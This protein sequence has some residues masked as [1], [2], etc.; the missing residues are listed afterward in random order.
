MGVRLAGVVRMK[1]ILQ[2]S[3]RNQQKATASA[4]VPKGHFAVY[5]GEMEKRFV[6]PICYLHHPS[7][8]TLLHK[9]EEEYGFEHP[10]GMLKVPC[11]EDDFAT[12]TSQMSS[13]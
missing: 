7:F 12:L 2:Q 4:D 5:V 11:H 8:Q 3:F 13:S 9:A 10:R 1:Q 6:V